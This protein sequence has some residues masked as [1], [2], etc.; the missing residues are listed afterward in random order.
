MN[1]SPEQKLFIEQVVNVFETGRKDG[2]FA[3]IA[4]KGQIE[5]RNWGLGDRGVKL[6][7]ETWA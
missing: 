2:D 3:G 5:G 1:L 6:Q 4:F 7:W